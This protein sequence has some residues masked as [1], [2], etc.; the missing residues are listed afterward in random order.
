MF[1]TACTIAFA[2]TCLGTA[3]QAEDCGPLKQITSLD[4]TPVPGGRFMVP[5]TINGTQQ[6]M[7][8][9]TAAGITNLTQDSASAMGLQP[10][11]ASHIKMLSTNGNVSQSYVQ[12]DF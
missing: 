5:V 8:L 6:Q 11:D 4:M 10:I 2:F 7:L 9:N 3:A 1:R 12:V